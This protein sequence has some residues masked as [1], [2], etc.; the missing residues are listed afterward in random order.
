MLRIYAPATSANLNVGF[1]SLGVALS[2][3]D[4]QRLGDVVQIDE[5]DSDFAFRAVGQFTHALPQNMQDNLCYLAYQLFAER[6]K[7]QGKNVKPLELTLEKNMPIGSGLGSSACSIVATLVALNEFHDKP[8]SQE[9]LLKLMGEL[10]G[11]V[12]GDVHYD[13]VA[14]SFLGGMQLMALAPKIC[15]PLPLFKHWYWVLA[16]SGICVPTADA[17]RILPSQY[18]KSTCIQQARAFANFV[19]ACYTQDEAQATNALQDLLAEPYRQH[20][21]PNFA[22]T[23]AKLLEENAL[24][25]GISGSGPTMFAIADSLEKAQACAQIFQQHYLQNENG[26]VH[27]CQANE[28]GAQAI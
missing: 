17:R 7:A 27:I 24:M 19:Q 2:P 25:A 16:Y 18:D 15:Q 21:L 8:F 6:L 4:G 9:A 22:E 13:N 1:D 23:K 14:P 11:R 12:S 5:R 20:L 3:I 28:Q 26:F 10:E